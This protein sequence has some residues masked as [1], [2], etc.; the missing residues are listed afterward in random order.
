MFMY[1]P[2]GKTL[3]E[4]AQETSAS[5]NGGYEVFLLADDTDDIGVIVDTSYSV[6]AILNNHPELAD[7][8]VK[9]ENDFYGMTVLRVLKEN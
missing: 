2:I 3:A 7:Y 4:V 9:L 5:F 6:K 8:K 1:N